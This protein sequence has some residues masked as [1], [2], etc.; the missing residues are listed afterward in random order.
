MGVYTNVVCT[1]HLLGSGYVEKIGAK[2]TAAAPGDPVLLSF[3]SCST[4]QICASGHPAHCS[5]AKEINFV[6]QKDFYDE[7]ASLTTETPS[8]T[9]SFFGQ[10]SFSNL[11]IAN[12]TSIVNAKTLIRSEDELKLF[13][14]LGCGIQTGSGT[15]VNVANATPDDTVAILGL[16][17]V[18]LSGIMA[19]KVRGCK[20]IIGIDKVESRLTL[21]KELGATH[22]VN[23]SSM[24]DFN[25]LIT[26]VRKL[27]DGYGSSITMDTTGYLPLIQAALDFT[28]I[29][30]QYIQIGTTPMDAKLEIEL[31]KFMVSG[32]RFIGAVE[33]DVVPQSYLPIM[34]GWYR[35]GKF[36]VNRLIEYFAAEK[37]MDAIGAMEGGAVVK[38]VI[39]W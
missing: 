37:F 4:C 26:Q 19:A 39:L 14:P 29:R 23:T 3:A 28:R 11:T 13:A 36:P 30:G 24:T 8:T 32:K 18:G 34:I 35:E 2:V 1:K 16:G 6:G 21:A 9:G 38:P 15:I 7:S 27:T 17:G 12:E 10:S 33:G 5:T 22:T 31:F 25:D 20:T